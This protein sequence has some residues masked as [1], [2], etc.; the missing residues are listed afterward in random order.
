M[1]LHPGEYANP[2]TGIVPDQGER[3]WIR[4]SLANYCFSMPPVRL[5]TAYA[6]IMVDLLD[7]DS[8]ALRLI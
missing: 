3:H 8:T 2:R 7:D 1:P 5:S 4:A 6:L